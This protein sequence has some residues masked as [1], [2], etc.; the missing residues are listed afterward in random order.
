MSKMHL[1]TVEKHMVRLQ[2][3][4]AANCDDDLG[5]ERSKERAA[6]W[7]GYLSHK[8]GIVDGAGMVDIDGA[9]AVAFKRAYLRAPREC[10]P[11]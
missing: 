1:N 3:R 11:A 10:W 6:W 7:V 5:R 8:L 9:I 4:Q 2:A